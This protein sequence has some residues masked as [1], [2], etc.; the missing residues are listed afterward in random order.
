MAP[1]DYDVQRRRFRGPSGKYLSSRELRKKIDNLSDSIRK[2]SG[3]LAAR[4]DAGEITAAEF[5]VAMRELL[6]SGHIIAASIGRGGRARM[7]A[8]DWGRVGKKIEWQY[9]YLDRF[10][11]K[12]ARNTLKIANTANR[13]RQY[14]SSIYISYANAFQVA[15]TEFVAAGGDTNPNKEMLCYLEQ[16]SQEGCEECTA[17]A[18]AGPMPVSEM[19]ELGDRICGDYCRCYIIFED[20]PEFQL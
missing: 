13:A 8:S 4:F 6:K 19:K 3:R 17:D 18:A 9:G 15:Q 1:H 10:T 2:E 12:L 5:N 20:E 7:T 11:G 14:V 16:N